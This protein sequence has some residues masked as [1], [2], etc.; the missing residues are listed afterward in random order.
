MRIN[1]YLRATEDIDF[2]I[3]PGRENGQRIIRALG[4]LA[5][6][7]ELEA[8]WFEPAANGEIENIRVADELII[9]LLFAANGETYASIAP[10]IR[11]IT[12][13]GIPIRVLDIDGLIKT[14]TD[15]RDKD[16]IDK[17]ALAEI[18]RGLAGK[19]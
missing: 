1:G 10:H 4:F 16:R 19:N 18:K 7:R 14:K 6:S 13:E 8:G 9:D 2:L 11:E 12:S 17:Q 3:R 5:S 15:Y